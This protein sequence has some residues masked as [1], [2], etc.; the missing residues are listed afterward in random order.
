[1]Q[2][3]AADAMRVGAIADPSSFV[4]G[5]QSISSSIAR[6]RGAPTV[7]TVFRPL[8]RYASGALDDGDVHRGIREFMRTSDLSRDAEE[9]L[10]LALCRYNPGGPALGYASK[11]VS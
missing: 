9:D 2:P 10:T 6:R 8:D 7:H 4:L 1:M 5:E 3:H 11:R